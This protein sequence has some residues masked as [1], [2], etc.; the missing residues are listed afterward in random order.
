MSECIPILPFLFLQFEVVDV[1]SDTATW[2][3]PWVAKTVGAVAT[4]S[5]LLGKKKVLLRRH[6]TG[7]HAALP[8]AHRTA[9]KE[10]DCQLDP[11]QQSNSP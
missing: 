10:Q 5:N 8:S 11:Y 6:S 9:A 1:I 7:D 4:A 3:T 2:I